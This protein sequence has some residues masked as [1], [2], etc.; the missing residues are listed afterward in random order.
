MTML[1]ALEDTKTYIESQIPK[2][3]TMLA[4]Y[5]KQV[6]SFYNLDF[7]RKKQDKGEGWERVKATE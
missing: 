7:S 1:T 5:S 3:K 2:I 4:S 6:L